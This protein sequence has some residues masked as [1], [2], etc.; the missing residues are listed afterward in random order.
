MGPVQLQMLDGEGRAPEAAAVPAKDFLKNRM[1]NI[2]RSAAM[3]PKGVA[4]GGVAKGV[5]AL[6]K[7]MKAAKNLPAANF[8][9]QK[10]QKGG[11][12]PGW[13]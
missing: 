9:G 5:S 7:T 3:I 2:K 1:A 6:S 4:Q 12:K 8:A 10:Q 11:A 13:R